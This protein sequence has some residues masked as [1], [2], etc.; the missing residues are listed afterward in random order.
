MV[1]Q[2]PGGGRKFAALT[3]PD[4]QCPLASLPPRSDGSARP[5]ERPAADRPGT[6]RSC[7][8]WPRGGRQRAVRGAP[9][10]LLAAPGGVARVIGTPF[11]APEGS[12]AAVL[13]AS[14][15]DLR[16]DHHVSRTFPC[17]P[18]R[19]SPS[20]PVGGTVD[21]PAP[22]PAAGGIPT[23]AA[24]GAPPLAAAAGRP[25]GTRTCPGCGLALPVEAFAVDRSKRSGRKSRCRS[26]DCARAAG[27][28]AAHRVQRAEYSRALRGRRRAAATAGDPPPPAA[29][30]CP[31]CRL[32]LPAAAFGVDVTAASGRTSWC[33]RCR[34]AAQ[35]TRRRGGAA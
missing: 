20:A 34:A 13:C 3:R 15:P 12:P 16:D 9:C 31:C 17:T 23:A 2:A 28:Y 7:A 35:A 18:V 8:P 29:A 19:T 30:R 21:A 6:G 14:G 11:D 32:R 5:P 22:P 27:Y 33:R 26:C 24:G 1:H 25:A 10:A 4:T